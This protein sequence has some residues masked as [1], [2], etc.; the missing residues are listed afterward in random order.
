ML[1]GTLWIRGTRLSSGA[2]LGIAVNIWHA[3]QEYTIQYLRVSL[4]L[5]QANV[6]HT[7]DAL[8]TFSCLFIVG[9]VPKEPD[10]SGRHLL[11]WAFAD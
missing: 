11:P 8:V 1:T 6:Q 4:F 10:P 3:P 2:P 9:G 7:S 5:S